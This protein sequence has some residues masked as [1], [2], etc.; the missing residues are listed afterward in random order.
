LSFCFLDKDGELCL[1]YLSAR[2]AEVNEKSKCVLCEKDAEATKLPGK[3]ESSVECNTCKNYELDHFFEKAYTSMEKEKRAMISAYTRE[4]FEL[5]KE[6]IK[7]GDPDNLKEIIEEYRNKTIDEKLDNLIFH[8]KRKSNYLGS[9]VTWDEKKDYPITYSLS[10]E[11][12]LKI[13][14]V[15]KDRDL[16]LWK[17]RDKFAELTE[18]GWRLSTDIKRSR[19]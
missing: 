18:E 6:P 1:L 10:L 15:A 7:L 8:L 12:F 14:I 9:S 11:G 5:G 19:E 4:C 13:F 17:S 3:S 2:E 16:L